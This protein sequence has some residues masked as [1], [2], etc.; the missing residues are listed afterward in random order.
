MRVRRFGESA[1]VADYTVSVH[2]P[3][4]LGGLC[5]ANN[6]SCTRVRM[7]LPKASL[8]RFKWRHEKRVAIPLGRE[9]VDLE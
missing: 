9:G 5:T 7:Q 1:R 3:P 4:T 6:E 2:Q 8:L